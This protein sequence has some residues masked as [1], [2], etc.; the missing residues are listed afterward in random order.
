MLYE[1]AIT[2]GL[3]AGELRA[4]MLAHLDTDSSAL[5]LDAT[6]TKNRK[7]GFQPLPA[8]LVDRLKAFG[9]SGRAPTC[10]RS[11]TA[12][13]TQRST[14]RPLPCSFVPTHIARSM[15]ED[16]EA[17]GIAKTTPAGTVDFHALRV[18]YV[19]FVIQAGASGIRKL[20]SWRGIRRRI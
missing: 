10:M 5:R 7:H 12:G 17:A 15:A 18:A 4:L 9:E 8:A 6:W 1:V 19:S 2:T 11:T 3:R 13:R 16:L 20:R 14:C